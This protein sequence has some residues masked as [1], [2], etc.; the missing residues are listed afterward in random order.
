MTRY[1]TA[2]PNARGPRLFCF[3][4]GGGSA[5]TFADWQETLGPHI[6]VL[7]VQLPGREKRVQEPRFREMTALVTE[8][9][10]QIGP[11]LREPYLIYGHSMGALVG[12]ALSQMRLDQ[13]QRL[14]E[15]LVAGGAKAPHLPIAFTD[16]ESMPNADLGRLLVDLGGM[17]EVILRYPD[18]LRSALDLFRDD[19]AAC[20]ANPYRDAGPLPCP[21]I[22][23]T[24][25]RDRLVSVADATAWQQHTVSG[26][27][28]RVVPG[29]HFFFKE[30]PEEFMRAM[31]AVIANAGLAQEDTPA[32]SI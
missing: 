7:P 9:N 10:A 11:Y 12:H 8:L 32:R 16:A 14:P 13:G 28:P 23:F 27:R 31:R 22:A 1:L 6:T 17:S 29:G 30:S 26:S 21:V 3:H 25:D 5:A 2:A 4:H 20:L 19:L 18:W 24:G 15:V